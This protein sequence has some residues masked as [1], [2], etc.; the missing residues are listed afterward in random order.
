MRSLLASAI[1]LTQLCSSCIAYSV[2]GSL[3]QDPHNE[4][5]AAQGLIGS[6]FGRPPLSAAFDYVVLGG[7][8]AGLAVA[9]RLAANGT[10]SVAVV[11]AGGFYELNNGNLS[12]IP[13]YAFFY[14]GTEPQVYNPLIDWN[15]HTTPQ[16]VR[17]SMSDIYHMTDLRTGPWWPIRGVSAGPDFRR[18]QRTQSDV[19]SPVCLP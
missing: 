19:V 11:E 18:K 12:E 1:A 2:P 7:G 15:Q 14:L 9:R 16:A 10:N 6:H 8:T 13:A 3:L 5:V 17:P 4:I